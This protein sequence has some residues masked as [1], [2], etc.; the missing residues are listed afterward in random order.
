VAKFTPEQAASIA[1]IKQVIY[2]WGE[3][4]DVNSGLKIIEADVLT[5]DVQYNVGGEWRDGLEA[6]QAFYNARWDR[7]E[8]AGGAPVM[9]H[10][11]TNLR[12]TFDT[13]D[14]ARITYQLLFFAATGEPPFVGKADPLAVA[15]VRMECRRED[16]GHWR[17]SRFDSGQIFQRG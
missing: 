3:E 17:I 6:V 8:A 10:L 4:L 2:D 9:R 5:K 13:D 14:H 16:D 11:L 1:G 7:L 12:I 15:D